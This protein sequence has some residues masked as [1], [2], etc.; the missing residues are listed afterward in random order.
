MPTAFAP[1]LLPQIEEVA[2][3]G[4][5][6]QKQANRTGDKGTDKQGIIACY[7]AIYNEAYSSQT[8]K[9]PQIKYAGV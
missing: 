9:R 7:E 6:H 4:Y 2:V 3:K 5:I 8:D 1:K